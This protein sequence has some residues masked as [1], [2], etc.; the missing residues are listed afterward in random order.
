ME[1]PQIWPGFDNDPEHEYPVGGDIGGHGRVV[2]RVIQRPAEQRD[3]VAGAT[4]INRSGVA[5]AALINMAAGAQGGAV[6]SNG[7]VTG[8]TGRGMV[9][10]EWLETSESEDEWGEE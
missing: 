7:R 2:Q 4:D 3:T 8:V 9:V 6:P 5:A 1:I 10:D